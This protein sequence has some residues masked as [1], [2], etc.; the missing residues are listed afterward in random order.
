MLTPIARARP[1]RSPRLPSRLP[2]IAAPSINAAV[3]RANH[4]PPSESTYEAP[5]KL[6]VTDSEATGI[7]PSS[8]PSKAS[9]KNAAARTA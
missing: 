2:P 7:N 4:T 8:T 9:P 1:I 3:N 5:S 6:L